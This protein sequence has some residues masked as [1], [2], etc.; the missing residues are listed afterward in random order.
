MDDIKIQRI[1]EL[2][3]KERNGEI[4]TPEEKEEQTALRREYIDAVKRNMRNQL[5]G[6]KKQ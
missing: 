5:S 2:S 3:K 6:I 1:N 4:L